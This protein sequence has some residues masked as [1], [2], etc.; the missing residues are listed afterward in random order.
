MV[1]PISHAKRTVTVRSAPRGKKPSWGRFAPTMLGY[2]L[3]Q[4]IRRVLTEDVTYGYVHDD[5]WLLV[6]GYREDFRALLSRGG[7][8]LQIED[9]GRALWW[10]FAGGR[11]NHTLKY[12]LAE[13]TGWKVVADNFRLRFEGDGITHASVEAAIGALTQRRFWEARHRRRLRAGA[14]PHDRQERADLGLAPPPAHAAPAGVR[15]ARR[16]GADRAAPTSLRADAAL[17][18]SPRSCRPLSV[19]QGR[20]FAGARRNLPSPKRAPCRVARSCL[21]AGRRSGIKAR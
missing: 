11:I 12:A 6:E 21:C 7:R 5:A 15:R 19:S 17:V 18:A 13:T 10:T 9:E 2:E 14:G 16:R 4:R 3:C 8:A 20:S 1:D